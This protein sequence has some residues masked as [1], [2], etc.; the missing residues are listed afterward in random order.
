MYDSKGFWESNRRSDTLKD[1]LARTVCPAGY[2]GDTYDSA[3]A[4]G[5]WTQFKVTLK[6]GHRFFWR[7]HHNVMARF[8]SAAAMGIIL[9]LG[10]HNI[11]GMHPDFKT[12]TFLSVFYC[13]VVYCSESA[14]EEVPIIV[15]ERATFY[16]EIDSKFFSAFPYYAARWMAQQPLLLAQGFVLALP[17]FW[18]TIGN[19]P[20][21]GEAHNYDDVSQVNGSQRVA[22]F[23]VFYAQCF[24]A[25]S[26]SATFSQ[27]FASMS[28]NE[29]VGNVLYFT[30]CC[31]SRL[32][33]GFI[34]FIQ[35]MGGKPTGSSNYPFVRFFGRLVNA[36][37]FFKYCFFTFGDYFI[38]GTGLG[39]PFKHK[40]NQ[41]WRMI[42]NPYDSDAGRDFFFMPHDW[43]RTGEFLPSEQ[44][45]IQRYQFVIGLVGL[46][47]FYNIT[48]FLLLACKRH[49]KR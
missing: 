3:Y 29:G 5:M 30:L 12:V 47:V 26:V 25:L 23:L 21:F 20:A 18:L 46:I 43:L 38:N 39:L 41:V 27:F 42:V 10:L 7:D 35:N 11:W 49:D 14:A 6:R 36:M 4:T 2:E 32:F 16:R 9:G 24:L 15:N 28:P 48:T 37:D 33:S 1:E 34:I 40:T 44:T 13:T 19:F 45:F 17:L 31:L 22:D 8:L